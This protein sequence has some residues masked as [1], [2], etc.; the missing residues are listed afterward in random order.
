M[1]PKYCK[2]VYWYFDNSYF[3]SL[4]ERE[5]LSEVIWA[6]ALFAVIY[7]GASL[8]MSSHKHDSKMCTSKKEMYHELQEI[9]PEQVSVH[10]TMETVMHCAILGPSVEGSAY[11]AWQ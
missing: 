7:S 4:Q 9:G 10:I 11:T 3:R 8:D 6:F 5:M 1:L 2:V